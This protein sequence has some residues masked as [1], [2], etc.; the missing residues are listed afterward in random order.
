MRSAV[1]SGCPSG[2]RAETLIVPVLPQ[3]T[4]V[5]DTWM[6]TGALLLLAPLGRTEPPWPDWFAIG[7]PYG[8]CP[9]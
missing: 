6:L 1:V 3:V 4:L 9:V 7:W 8:C 5:G 2:P